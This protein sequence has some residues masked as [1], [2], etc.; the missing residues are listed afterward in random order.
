[1]ATR[2]DGAAVH[3]A[4]L[5]WLLAAI[6]TLPDPERQA[7]AANGAALEAIS[8]TALDPADRRIPATRSARRSAPRPQIVFKVDPALIAGL[9]LHGPHFTVGNSWRADLTR[10]L[11]DLTP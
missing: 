7:V 1:M 6:R 5:N 4:F 8:A 10:I 2:L 9:E 3:T 11:A